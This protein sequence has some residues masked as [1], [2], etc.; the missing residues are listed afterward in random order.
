LS[1]PSYYGADY[2]YTIITGG[3]LVL[4]FGSMIF[5]KCIKGRWHDEKRIEENP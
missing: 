2:G 4:T 5:A 1:S 3:A